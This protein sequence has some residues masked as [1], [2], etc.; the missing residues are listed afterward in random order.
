MVRGP[1]AWCIRTPGWESLEWAFR[2][3]DL[4]NVIGLFKFGSFECFGPRN[5]RPNKMRQI[6]LGICHYP[7]LLCCL[8]QSQIECTAKCKDIFS[9]HKNSQVEVCIREQRFSICEP[10]KFLKEWR[11]Q[12][13]LEGGA[14]LK[15]SWLKKTFFTNKYDIATK[16]LFVTILTAK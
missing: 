5:K 4:L 7:S 16:C 9:I 10:W 15:K 2:V 12:S 1:I 3:F 6:C 11:T 13:F 14:W 8:P